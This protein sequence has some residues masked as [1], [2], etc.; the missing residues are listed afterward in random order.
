[1][2]PVFHPR[3]QTRARSAPDRPSG[4]DKTE[5]PRANR[6]GGAKAAGLPPKKA[7]QSNQQPRGTSRRKPTRTRNNGGGEGADL[8]ASAI[9]RVLLAAQLSLRVSGILA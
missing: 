1:M 2:N 9:L 6:T 3:A 8:P 5:R 4:A 7:R